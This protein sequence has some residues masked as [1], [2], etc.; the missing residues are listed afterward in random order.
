MITDRPTGKGAKVGARRQAPPPIERE[1]RDHTVTVAELRELVESFVKER[2]W[3]QFHSP[4]NLSMALAVEASELMDLFKWLSD[5]EVANMLH[6][7]AARSQAADEIADVL[8]YC[9]AFANRTQI[10]IAR[11][12]TAKILKNQKKY[13]VSRFKGRF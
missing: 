9:L 12:V 4:K 3:E 5:E 8:I 2:D 7:P 1:R 10:D 11:A 6:R 13:P